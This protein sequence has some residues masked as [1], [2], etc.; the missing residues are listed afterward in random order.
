MTQSK[1]LPI[2]SAAF[3]AALLAGLGPAQAQ[4]DPASMIDSGRIVAHRDCA[5]CHAVDATGDSHNVAAP[6]FRDLHKRLVVEELEERLL[7]QLLNKHTNMPQFR[8][9]PEQLRDLTA[10]LKSIQTRENAALTA[11]LP[12][13]R[14]TRSLARRPVTKRSSRACR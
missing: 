5:M 1:I 9:S 10:Y 12:L 3:V 11:A 7:M 14:S 13:L 8:L 6:P 2:L 4:S